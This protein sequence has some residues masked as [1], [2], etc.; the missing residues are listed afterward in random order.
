[1]HIYWS[2]GTSEWP[3]RGIHR[4]IS[5][6]NIKL[7][8]IAFKLYSI[9]CFSLSYSTK[10][11]TYYT[12]TK[13]QNEAKIK[14]KPILAKEFKGGGVECTRCHSQLDWPG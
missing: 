11:G 3:Q 9:I 12:V 10:M 13:V 6:V 7:W 14:E 5:M 4:I 8:T 2:V 1:M